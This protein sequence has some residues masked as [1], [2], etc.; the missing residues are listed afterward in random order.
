MKAGSQTEGLSQGGGL[1]GRLQR[2][3]K[4]ASACCDRWA[5][6]EKGHCVCGGKVAQLARQAAAVGGGKGISNS[7]EAT[8]P[9]S[10]SLLTPATQ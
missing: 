2:P 4:V 1:M 10:A 6:K 5:P 7:R 9:S 8:Q 3:V